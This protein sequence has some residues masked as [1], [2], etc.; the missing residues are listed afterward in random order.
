[1]ERLQ[2]CL[3]MA[4]P[5]GPRCN[6]RCEYCYYI[7]KEKRFPPGPLRM[8]ESLL[9]RYIAGRFEASPG[10]G[11]HFEWHGGEPTLAGMDFFRA[12]I[13]LQRRYTPVGRSVTNGLQTNGFLIDGAWADFL[14]RERFSVG[15]SLDGPAEFHD[16]FRK[17]VDGRPTH[18]RVADAFRLLKE[19][20]V[21]CTVLCVLHAVNTAEP[22]GV[23]DYFRS[24]GVSYLQFL[25]LVGAGPLSAAPE[26]IAHFLCRIF[27]RWIAADVGRM[28]IQTFDEAL[29]PLYGVPH[30]L[31]V[32]RET[33][34]DAA[35]L[36]YDGSFYACDHFVDPEHKIGT[37]LERKLADLAADPAMA[38]FGKAKRDHLPQYCR[39][40][41]VL[42]FCNGGCPKHRLERTPDGEAG[43]NYLCAAYR[44][45]FLHASPQLARLA[46]HM[47]AGMPLRAFRVSGT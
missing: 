26:A 27:D 41:P 3:V 30:A 12:V 42:A 44:A 46:D 19:R 34:G 22:D 40:C 7:D 28:V 39:E 18:A 37:I 29:R 35:V 17:T 14:A 8:S 1:M 47:K 21:F 31:C 32:H 4:K 9:E 25:P 23:Y 36:E 20:R 24:L 45:F 43:L 38:T 15:L 5:A 33:C 10:P 11:T 13:R 2:E 6:L 16:R